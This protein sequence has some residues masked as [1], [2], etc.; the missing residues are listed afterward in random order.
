MGK[1]FIFSRI[2]CLSDLIENY[3]MPFFTD[4]TNFPFED[5][6]ENIISKD[7]FKITYVLKTL[8]EDEELGTTYSNIDNASED[9]LKLLILM[10]QILIQI[11][12]Q[13]FLKINIIL[14][15]PQA[16]KAQI[17]ILN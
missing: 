10:V 12:I 5:N 17:I 16:K 2:Y 4:N 9:Y 7:P 13:H 15:F 14:Q 8:V 1:L 11:L 3:E 6:N